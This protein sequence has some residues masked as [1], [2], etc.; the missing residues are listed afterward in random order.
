MREEGD[1]LIVPSHLKNDSDDNKMHVCIAHANKMG[2]VSPLKREQHLPPSLSNDSNERRVLD[3]SKINQMVDLN[4][5]I[6]EEGVVAVSCLLTMEDSLIKRNYSVMPWMGL[7]DLGGITSCWQ[8]RLAIL[9]NGI[10]K[11]IKKYE[12]NK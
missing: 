8:Q 3:G 12:K 2:V 4:T 7:G 6:T 1:E 5:S 11:D 10:L 9:S